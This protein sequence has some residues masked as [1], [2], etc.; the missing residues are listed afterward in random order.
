MKTIKKHFHPAN[1]GQSLIVMV[2]I[3]CFTAGVVAF[4]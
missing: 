4:F 1:V 2:V 3:L